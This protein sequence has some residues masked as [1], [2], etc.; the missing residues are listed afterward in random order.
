MVGSIDSALR[1]D[2][3]VAYWEGRGGRRRGEVKGA[4]NQGYSPDTLF[5]TA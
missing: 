5:L 2:W 4:Y 3:F 1:S